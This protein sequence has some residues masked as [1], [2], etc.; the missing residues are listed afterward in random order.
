MGLN[1]F[2]FNKNYYLEKSNRT[3]KRMGVPRLFPFIT[4]TFQR[5]VKHFKP[6]KSKSSSTDYL[7]I[8]A[9]C[10]LHNACQTVYN[11]GARPSIIDRFESMNSDEKFRS[12]CE[13]FIEE[14]NTVCTTVVPDKLLIITLDGPAPLAKQNQQRER[15]FRASVNRSSE[16]KFDS[17][18]ITPG[19]QFMHDVSKFL[20]YAIRR[21]MNSR[22]R[23]FDVIFSPPTVPG[24]GEHKLLDWIRSLPE[25]EKRDSRFTMF[26]PDGDLIMLTLSSHVRN[27]NLFRA[28]QYRR[29]FYHLLDMGYIY[30]HIGD[31]FKNKKRDTKDLVNDWISLGFFVGNDFL[32]KVQMFHLLEDGL[33]FM[34]DTSSKC[35]HPLTK[36]GSINL[37]GLREFTRIVGENEKDFIESQKSYK[38]RSEV[39]LN[40]TLLRNIVDGKLDYESYRK[41]YYKKSGIIDDEDVKRMCRDYLKTLVWIYKYYVE[42]LPSWTWVYPW[43]YSP[44]M[45]DFW[46]FL[47]ETPNE[48]LESLLSF[49][50]GTPSPPFLQLLSVLPSTSSELLPKEYRKHLDLTK[51]FFVD[52]EGK[53]QEYQGVS[54]L[55]FVNYDEVVRK[56]N[57]VN[58]TS[59]RN[60][61]GKDTRFTYDSSYET[62]YR[63]R[64][65]EIESNK[66]RVEYL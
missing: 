52:Y 37:E 24:E 47:E 9:N 1:H 40:H 20:K 2:L 19:T 48:E 21:E 44:L 53:L 4:K 64:Y 65:G 29:G 26:G 56:Y 45:K 55:P 43:H 11:Y 49:D 50:M 34:L 5:C 39:F 28:D 61:V 36:G 63:S 60:V 59:S 23:G 27:I 33:E 35:K 51:D 18:S 13:L 16:C 22:W 25:E 12:V 30:R 57:S 54:H 17:N 41:D 32:P 42:G 46:K 66:V 38:P 14:I 8:D 15:R 3:I 7:L 62:V 6:D 58:V 31:I 10:F